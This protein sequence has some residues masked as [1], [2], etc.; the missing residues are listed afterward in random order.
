MNMMNIVIFRYKSVKKRPKEDGIY[1][2]KI[3]HENE[4]EFAKIS[5]I[6]HDGTW[7]D[8]DVVAWVDLNDL[9]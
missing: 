9:I 6:F 4:E 7:L 3:K 1:L 8:D 2:V 5:E